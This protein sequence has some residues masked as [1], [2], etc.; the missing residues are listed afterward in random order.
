M[1]VAVFLMKGLLVLRYGEPVIKNICIR[2]DISIEIIDEA[3][4]ER[5]GSRSDAIILS[6]SGMSIIFFRD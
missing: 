5:E 4:F 6:L 3:E 1:E 2:S